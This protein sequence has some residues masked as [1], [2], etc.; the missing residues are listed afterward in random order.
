MCI[1][2]RLYL[3]PSADGIGI[4]IH[5]II[6]GLDGQKHVK[7]ITINTISKAKYLEQEIEKYLNIIDREVPEG[8][9]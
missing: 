5:M 3:K 6:N 7:L 8:I 9:K 4:S 2:D 1:R